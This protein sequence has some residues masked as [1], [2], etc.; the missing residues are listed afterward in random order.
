[1]LN[2]GTLASGGGEY[3]VGEVATSAE[4]YYAGRGESAGRWVGSVATELGLRGEVDP[5]EFRRVLDGRHP[6]TG[7]VL[8]SGAG[9]ASR[10]ASRRP[11]PAAV[12]E[13]PVLD[14]LQ[15]AVSVGRSPRFVR[16]LLAEGDR[17]RERQADDASAVPPRSY[18][19]GESAASGGGSARWTVARRELERYVSTQTTKEHR[20]A[21]DLTLRPPKSVSV[22]WALGDDQVR[23]EVRAAHSA[24]VD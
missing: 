17:F 23:A 10:A 7:A 6:E 22:L 11:Q 21:Y 18:L 12:E 19:L 16:M 15:V 24:A 13:A 8:V 9:S 14:V 5:T 20:A 4:D 2:I 1:M 3:Y